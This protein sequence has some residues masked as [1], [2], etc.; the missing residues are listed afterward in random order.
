MEGRQDIC[1]Q[2]LYYL[3]AAPTVLNELMDYYTLSTDTFQ[4]TSRFRAPRGY[5]VIRC[6]WRKDGKPILPLPKGEG[7]PSPKG[8]GTVE[9]TGP[10]SPPPKGEECTPPKGEGT[11][12]GAATTEGAEDL[13]EGKEDNDNDDDGSGGG[14]PRVTC[15]LVAGEATLTIQDATAADTGRYVAEAHTEHGSVETS[16]NVYVHGN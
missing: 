14:D 4:L 11:A 2:S 1:S 8:E 3:F 7:T 9:G 6:E 12:E 13:K 5:P 10:T 16:C 15:S